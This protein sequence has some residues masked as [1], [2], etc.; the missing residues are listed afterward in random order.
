MK[1]FLQKNAKFSSARGSAPDPR[2]SDG[3]GLCPQTPSLARPPLA[4]SGWG[5]RPQ[6]PQTAPPLRISGY[7]P[8]G[9]CFD[10]HFFPNPD[11]SNSLIGVL[12]LRLIGI[13]SNI[14]GMFRQV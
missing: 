7:A 10:D 14:K 8:E 13:Q 11:I 6:T 2:A 3:W 9:T 4:S 12:I 5:L 1:L